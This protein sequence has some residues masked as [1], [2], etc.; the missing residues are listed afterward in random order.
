MRGV[1]AP[2][3]D[4]LV[5]RLRAAGCVYAEDEAH[6][7]VGCRLAIVPQG[8]AE[9][10]VVRMMWA[11]IEPEIAFDLGIFGTAEEARPSLAPDGPRTRPEDAGA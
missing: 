11:H 7:L 1:T 2:P 4:E 6:L 9:F 10:G 8:A 3:S 5:A